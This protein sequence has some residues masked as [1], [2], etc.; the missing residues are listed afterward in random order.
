MYVSYR[1]FLTCP[2]VLP[3]YVFIPDLFVPDKQS[4]VFAHFSISGWIAYYHLV[5]LC[6]GENCALIMDREKVD[7]L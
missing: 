2:L 6:I 7:C 4:G 1:T 3:Y 5:Y